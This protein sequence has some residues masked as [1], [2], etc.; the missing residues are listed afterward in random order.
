[1]DDIEALCPRVLVIDHGRLRFDGQL[2]ALV[3]RMAPH[4]RLGLSSP[5][6]RG[7]PPPSPRSPAVLDLLDEDGDALTLQPLVP[8]SDVPE[9]TGRLLRVAAVV[10]VEYRGSAGR[11]R[12]SARSSR[13][14]SQP[15]GGV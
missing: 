5:R 1:M 13:A 14:P 12:S 15:G 4:K 9:V 2:A 3:E 10:D 6:H 8:R 11:A 7:A